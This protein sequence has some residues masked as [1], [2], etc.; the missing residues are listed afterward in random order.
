M[1]WVVS[2]QTLDLKSPTKK[3][4]FES[5]KAI[6]LDLRTLNFGD[7]KFT[8]AFFQSY[9]G[10]EY[11]SAGCSG[12]SQVW[13]RWRPCGKKTWGVANL[14]SNI[15]GMLLLM[16][17]IRLTTWYVKNL[18]NNGINYISTGAGFLPSTVSFTLY[19]GPSNSSNEG[20]DRNLPTKHL[21]SSWWWLLGRRITDNF[22]Y[23]ACICFHWTH[24]IQSSYYIQKM[25]DRWL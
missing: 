24:Q 5:R 21:V 6:F 7:M 8:E 17:E 14:G 4:E 16:E 18:V 22:M 9:P 2:S 11:S 25:T 3:V 12:K 10:E 19:P 20:V 13:R 1:N 23:H 15:L